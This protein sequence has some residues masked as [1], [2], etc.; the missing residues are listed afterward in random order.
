MKKILFISFYELKEHMLYI[1]NIFKKYNYEIKNYPLFQYAYDA[2]DKI[3]NYKDHMDAFIKTA[4]PDIILWWFLDVPIS[5]FQFIKSNNPNIYYIMYNSDDP[6]N[7]NIDTLEKVKIFNLLVTPCKEYINKYKIY[8]GITNVL[9]IPPG[10]DPNYYY[11]IV[12][13]NAGEYNENKKKY[14]CDINIYC[15]NILL[16]ELENQ[17]QYVCRYNLINDIIEYCK[18]NGKTFKIYG[19]L[20]IKEYFKDNYCDDIDYF[21]FNKV[22][23]YSKINICTHTYCNKSLSLTEYEMKILGSG[24][25]LF[26]DK[27]KDIETF[28][29]DDVHYVM[30]DKNNYITQ[31]DKILNNYDNYTKIK[32]NGHE[33]SKQYT[34]DNFVLKIHIEI[35]K[36]FFAPS[37]YFELYEEDIKQSNIYKNSTNISNE[38]KL[39]ETWLDIGLKRNHVCYDFEVPTYFNYSLYSDDKKMDI[40]NVKKMYIQW[41]NEGRS[42]DYVIVFE[43]KQILSGGL[44]LKDINICTEDLFKLYTVF[45]DIKSSNKAIKN[46]SLEK[47]GIICKNNYNIK[48][49]KCLDVYFMLNN[50]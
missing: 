30:I 21:N 6:H 43:N 35:T 2:N 46:E 44:D 47:L 34:W 14:E 23:N 48:I 20:A 10:Y 29:E 8:C 16:N 45:N 25:L 41:V 31:I 26:M 11:P 18:N 33:L 22:F 39:W 5:V 13:L 40:K 32:C 3:D 9:W 42:E 50:I 49:N 1:S 37:L 19:P 4:N 17:N 12:N 7:I 38:T 27:I 36:Y 15:Y 28:F 24:G